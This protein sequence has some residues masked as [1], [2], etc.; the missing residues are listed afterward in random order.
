ME[1]NVPRGQEPF[2][3]WHCSQPNGLRQCPGFICTSP[4]PLQRGRVEVLGAPQVWGLSWESP[5]LSWTLL[6]MEFCN[7]GSPYS[8]RPSQTG[9]IVMCLALDLAVLPGPSQDGLPYIPS[10][11]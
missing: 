7:K 5:W 4:L 1:L 8:L 6:L 11:T 10:A 2:K 3:G 9:S